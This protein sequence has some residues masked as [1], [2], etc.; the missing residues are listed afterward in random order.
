MYEKW[1]SIFSKNIQ[2]FLQR[3]VSP[4][5]QE[6]EHLKKS[7]TCEENNR[8]WSHN[9]AIEIKNR[10]RR[11]LYMAGIRHGKVIDSRGA[12]ERLQEIDKTH[13]EQPTIIK[14]RDRGGSTLVFII[15][16][17]ESA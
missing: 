5:I 13:N 17:L 14:N 2:P 1:S 15:L 11:Y 12:H 7:L 4:V 6:F 10:R 3:T 9:R 16:I 8:R